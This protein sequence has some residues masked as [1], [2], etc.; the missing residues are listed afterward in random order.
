MTAGDLRIGGSTNWGIYEL[1][2][3]R[4]GGSADWG[5]GGSDDCPPGSHG[6]RQAL[7]LTS[8]IGSYPLSGE[9]A[10]V[11][12]EAAS[13]V[14]AASPLR[15]RKA[16]RSEVSRVRRD[17]ERGSRHVRGDSDFDAMDSANARADALRIALTDRWRPS[18]CSRLH[19]FPGITPFPPDDRTALGPCLSSVRNRHNLP[20]VGPLGERTHGSAP[21]WFTSAPIRA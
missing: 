21:R 2:D 13:S 17:R 18:V 11:R 9:T 15:D 16:E 20:A 10:Q 12:S 14:A 4:I 3:L 19:R 6:R 5:I 7:I 1:G 8:L